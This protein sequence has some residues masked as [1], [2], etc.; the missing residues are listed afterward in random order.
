MLPAITLDDDAPGGSS[1]GPDGRIEDEEHEAF[2]IEQVGDAESA[3][4]ANRAISKVALLRH[5]NEYLIRLKGRL[6]RRDEALDACRREIAELRRRCGL[7][8]L[9]EGF[10]CVMED[11]TFPQPHQGVFGE[12]DFIDQM[13]LVEGE[14]HQQQQQ[15]DGVAGVHEIDLTTTTMA[16]DD[17]NKMM[18]GYTHPQQHQSMDTS[19]F[20]YNPTEASLALSNSGN[21]MDMS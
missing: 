5:S 11:Q 8:Q 18:V 7:Q 20:H 16:Q 21:S 6:E 19:A 2:D 13:G 17:N 14:G 15:H 1:L 4:I 3:R 12:R 10:M 9:Q